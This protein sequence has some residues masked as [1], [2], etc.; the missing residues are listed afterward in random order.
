VAHR[1]GPAATL[2]VDPGD[3]VAWVE[4][5]EVRAVVVD[6]PPEEADPPG[7]VDG[8]LEEHAPRRAPAIRMPAR[9][10]TIGRA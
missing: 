7:V 1:A 2:A 5:G 6:D 4:P 10:A 8:E 3:V 9:V